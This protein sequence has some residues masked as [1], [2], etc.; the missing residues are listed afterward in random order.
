MRCLTDTL[1]E[2]FRKIAERNAE[3]TAVIYRDG[4]CTFAEID[5]QVE[6]LARALYANGV[7]KQDRAIIFLPHM[8]QWVITWLA[9]QRLGAVAVPIA[10]FAVVEN[11]QYIANDC[12]AKA[13]VC[14]QANMDKLPDILP[15]TPIQ[16]VILCDLETVPR[17]LG[18]HV[19][20]D[21]FAGLIR[22]VYPESPPTAVRP[23]EIAEIMYTSGTTGLPKGVPITHDLLLELFDDSKLQSDPVIPRGQGIALQGSPLNH[24]L[25]QDKGF[26]ALFYGESLILLPHFDTEELL[27]CIETYQVNI[28]LGTPTMCRMILD[29]AKIDQYC[30]DSIRYVFVS[31]EAI[32]PDINRR[33]QERVG[34][35]LYTGYG[36]T[37]VVG[38]VSA[39]VAGEDFPEG[40]AGKVCKIKQVM[41]VT[42]DTLEP[43]EEGRN[44]GEVLVSSDNMV[45]SYLNSPEET[46]KR[47]VT[48]NERLWYKSGDIIEIDDEGWVFFKERSISVIKHKG[49]RVGP[50]KV[51]KVLNKH[52][53]VANSCVLGIPD[54]Q[55]GE[56]I[57]ASVVLKSP[58]AKV[59][60]D[61]LIAWCE[62]YLVA[63]E[64]PQIIEVR[65][66]FPRN[67]TGKILRRK[68]KEE[69]LTCSMAQ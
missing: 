56:L 37:E 50:S 61:D 32:P 44:I 5:R 65:A 35:P 26:G 64:V 11:L 20:A 68:L 36:C 55:T 38:S 18:L 39:L 17:D 23:N 6:Q 69:I 8:P 10:H 27:R 1:D 66:E 14:S 57:H 2:A 16:Q 15:G 9:L 12:Q 22:G 7:R 62:E 19:Q 42:P 63:Y 47:F 28:L 67:E 21:S 48:L 30:L 54:D 52:P 46:A 60:P 34:S 24:I 25:G 58:Q 59:T 33:W 51:E 53:E 13:I 43:L 40:S 49:Y 31:G 41:L 45:C 4:Q 29:H 3:K